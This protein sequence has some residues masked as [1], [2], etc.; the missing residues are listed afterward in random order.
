MMK[1]ETEGN[2]PPLKG[3]WNQVAEAISN[4]A[5]NQS[6]LTNANYITRNF[7]DLDQ[8]FN[9]GLKPK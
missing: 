3:H 1:E 4:M 9:I 5:S 7:V 8:N 6:A 2:T